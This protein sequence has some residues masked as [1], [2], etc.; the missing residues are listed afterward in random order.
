MKPTVSLT[1]WEELNAWW[2]HSCA[3]THTPVVDD[4]AV[5]GGGNYQALGEFA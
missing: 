2:P 1:S 5:C 4:T 3:I